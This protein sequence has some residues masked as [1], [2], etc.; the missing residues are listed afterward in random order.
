MKTAGILLAWSAAFC[1]ATVVAQGQGMPGGGAPAQPPSLVAEVQAQFTAVSTNVVRSA[2]RFPEDKYKWTPPT[3][4]QVD[5]ATI[6]SWAQLVAHM[7]DDANGNCWMIAGLPAAP[8]SVE[9]GTP[10]PNDKSKADL[11]AGITEA[12]AT[13]T[14]AFGNVTPANMS[15]PAGGRGNA[16]KLGQL[17][18][19]VA[20][21]NEHYGN[22]VTYFRLAGL[23]P[24]STA[25]RPARGARPGGA[26]GAAP[27]GGM[28]AGR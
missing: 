25:D 6:R 23:A 20:H 19:Y 3:P 8:A 4:P 11:V 14:K 28:P 22:M 1:A 18:T 21:A 15:E 2:E 5:N 26:P 17:I 12:M 13:C 9:R 10:G 24:P 16:S 27:Q 7:T